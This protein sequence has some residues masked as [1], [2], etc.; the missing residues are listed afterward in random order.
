[1]DQTTSSSDNSDRCMLYDVRNAVQQKTTDLKMSGLYR[2]IQQPWRRFS[3]TFD[4]SRLV[5]CVAVITSILCIGE[6]VWIRRL[7]GGLQRVPND[8]FDNTFASYLQ[9]RT[10]HSIWH[11]DYQ[12]F[13]HNAFPVPIHSHNDYSHRMPL[14]EALGSGCI[15]VEADVHLHR[16]ELYVGHKTA[17]RRE[18]STLRA[19]YLEPLKRMIEAQNTDIKD[20][21]WKGIFNHAPKQTVILLIDHKTSGP[22]TLAELNIQLQPLRDV[23][24]LT[25]W[26]GTHRVMGPLTI[27]ATGNAPFPSILA[28]NST[29]RD[30]FFDAPLAHLPSIHDDYTTSTPSYA[31]NISNSYLASTPWH[32]LRTHPYPIYDNQLSQPLTASDTD[33]FASQLDQAKSRGLVTRYWDVP[34]KPENVREIAWRELVGRGVGLLNMDDM[35]VVRARARGWGRVVVEHN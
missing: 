5:L 30:I 13:I 32:L 12:S 9:G 2:R 11:E 23:N 7:T 3:I 22:E 35:G 20:G 4:L 18:A 8:P 24:F 14:F 17:R 27:A 34:R 10:S 6:F 29:H 31:Y 33:M 28:L 19:M 1:M 21:D 25:Y 15:S 26:N 16:S